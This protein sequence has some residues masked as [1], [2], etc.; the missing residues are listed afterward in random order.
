[1]AGELKSKSGLIGK[2]PV[3]ETGH[4]AGSNPVSSTFDFFVNLG[5]SI[6]VLE[7]SSIE[8]SGKKPELR[9]K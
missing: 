4:H 8:T 7:L 5:G 6:S 9:K 3:L 1:V 2:P